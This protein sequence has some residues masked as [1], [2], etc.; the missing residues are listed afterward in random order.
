LYTNIS[1][2][3]VVD[4]LRS[5]SW[6]RSLVRLQ[7]FYPDKKATVTD[8]IQRAG[9]K[10]TVSSGLFGRLSAMRDNLEAVLARNVRRIE[11]LH[12]GTSLEAGDRVNLYAAIPIIGDNV[13]DGGGGDEADDFNGHNISKQNNVVG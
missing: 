8:S 11:A 4:I 12:N 1:S 13:D 5:N 7:T 9:E 10:E 3:E 2:E 6:R